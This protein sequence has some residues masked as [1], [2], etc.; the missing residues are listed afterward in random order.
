MKLKLK[1]LLLAAVAATT[2]SSL[3]DSNMPGFWQDTK[4]P[5]TAKYFYA[6]L[7]TTVPDD[8]WYAPEFDDSSWETI[9]GAI[10]LNGEPPSK[11]VANYSVYWL[12]SRFNIDDPDNLER[13]ELKVFHDDGCKVYL[14]GT[15]VYDVGSVIYD[16]SENSLDISLFKRGENLLAVYVADTGGGDAFIDFGLQPLWKD[17][18]VE[19]DVQ[20]PGTLGDIILAKVDDFS[21]VLSIR[22]SG[23]LDS[24]DIETLSK[25]LTNMQVLDMAKVDIKEIG[26]SIFRDNNKLFKVVLPE[27]L[28]SVG[29][30]AFSNCKKLTEVIFPKGLRSIGQYAFQY[31]ALSSLAL[32]EGLTSMGRYAF[33]YC[34]QL[35][36]LSVP[37]TLKDILSET[38]FEDNN[39]KEVNFSEGL[40]TIGANAF[41]N[42]NRIEKLTFPSSLRTIY[43]GAFSENRRLQEINLNAGLTTIGANA[44]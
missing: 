1:S 34:R 23:K 33:R 44:F 25:R 12:R 39:L 9:E 16:P 28:E 42:N 13:V 11:W 22:I 14:N 27:N 19:A 8:N 35:E 24:S 38:F 36:K 21:D 43:S 40:E 32:P 5:W 18:V 4:E 37:S 20:T 26:N 3:A 41:H 30:L 2:F 7:N 31:T 29:E 17:Q 6:P 10:Y 15:K